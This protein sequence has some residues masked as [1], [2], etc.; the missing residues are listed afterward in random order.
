MYVFKPTSQH[1]LVKAHALLKF[2]G[3]HEKLLAMTTYICMY[4][5]MYA[6]TL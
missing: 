5:G 1:L 4:L 3:L 6:S 2:Y